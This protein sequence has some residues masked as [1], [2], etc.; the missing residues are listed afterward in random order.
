MAEDGV[1]LE[2]LA[3]ADGA[4]KEAAKVIDAPIDAGKAHI[5]ALKEGAKGEEEKIPPVSFL[6]LFQF[7]TRL[8]I[9]LNIIGVGFAIAQGSCLVRFNVFSSRGWLTSLIT[10]HF[11]SRS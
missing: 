3:G 10:T 1:E 6:S 5:H 11:T 9:F 2:K 4:D 7:H 8:E